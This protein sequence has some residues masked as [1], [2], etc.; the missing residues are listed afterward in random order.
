MDTMQVF[1]RT[2]AP[3]A[4]PALCIVWRVSLS[5]MLTCSWC[6]T[7][8]RLTRCSWAAVLPSTMSR[9]LSLPARV[10]SPGQAEVCV[11]TVSLAQQPGKVARSWDTPLKACPGLQAVPAGLRTGCR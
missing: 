9:L 4:P 2:G 7:Q 10:R 6:T 5:L 1:V 11:H 3:T 8:T